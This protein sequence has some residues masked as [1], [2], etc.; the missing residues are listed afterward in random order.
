MSLNPPPIVI[1][2]NYP[3][4]VENVWNAITKPDLM[5]IWYF[6]AIPQ[7]EPRV[8]FETE[9]NVH[10]EGRDFLH[11]WQVTDVAPSH[12]IAYRWTY[13]GYPGDSIVNWDLAEIAEGTQLVFKQEFLEPFPLDDPIFSR[14]SGEEGWSYLVRESLN[15]FLRAD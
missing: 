15:S 9:F 4:S 8:G 11:Q 12:R 1:E 13:A 2:Q 3:T 5:R 6:E 7:F 14:E 10:C